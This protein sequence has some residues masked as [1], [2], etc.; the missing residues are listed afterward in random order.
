MFSHDGQ[1]INLILDQILRTST[2][3]DLGNGVLGY[4]LLAERLA[5]RAT[6]S[7]R[8]APESHVNQMARLTDLE[9]DVKEPEW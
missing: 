3:E 1:M 8:E 6:M 5:M 2:R 9:L 7:C 4:I